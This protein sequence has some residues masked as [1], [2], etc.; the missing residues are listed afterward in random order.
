M[1]NQMRLAYHNNVRELYIYA[2]MLANRKEDALE[3][4]KKTYCEIFSKG[5]RKESSR[6]LERDAK[7]TIIKLA[8]ADGGEEEQACRLSITEI[9]LIEMRMSDVAKEKKYSLTEEEIEKVYTEIQR[10]VLNR[11]R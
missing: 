4:V 10:E 3:L 2:R 1:K 6:N 7:K 8:K 5:D 11:S 9:P